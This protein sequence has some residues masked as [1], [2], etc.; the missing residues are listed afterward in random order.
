MTAQPNWHATPHTLAAY[1]EGRAETAEAWS[2]E[3]HLVTCA[4]CRRRLRSHLVPLDGRRLAEQREQLLRRLP[5]RPPAYRRLSL[6][7][8]RWVLRPG[9]IITVVVSSAA[10]SWLDV[11]TAGD[12]THG[13]LMWLLAPAVP[14][15]GV[16]LASVSENDPCR[17]AVVAAPAALLRLTL[18]RTLALL[19]VAIPLAAGLGG[20]RVAAGGDAGWSVAWLLPSVALAAS[21]LALGAVIGVER[22]ARSVA[23][24]WCVAAL[25]PSLVRTGGDLLVSLRIAAGSRAQPAA[26]LSGP[27]QVGWA[28]LII[29]ATTVLVLVRNRFE[30]VAL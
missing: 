2:L 16:A 28:L 20:I 24:L 27:A 12:G 19:V 21:A 17:E 15:V 13:S 4:R 10:V 7:W 5:A 1:A 30:R 11:L 8:L 22:A 14:V 18:W 9:P 3:A 23:V 26:L 25:G 6:W 29:L